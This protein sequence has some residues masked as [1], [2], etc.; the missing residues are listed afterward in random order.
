M[1]LPIG[2]LKYLFNS[3]QM[4]ISDH[5]KHMPRRYGANYGLSLSIWD[6]LFGSVHWPHSGRDI[7]LGF[8]G[9]DSYPGDFVHQMARPF[10]P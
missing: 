1:H 4:H 8:D 6:W 10:R 5:A 9:V 3:P 2:P 7:E